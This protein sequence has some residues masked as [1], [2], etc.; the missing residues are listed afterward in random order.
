SGS[1]YVSPFLGRLDDISEDGVLLVSKIAELF[2]THNLDTQIIAASVRHPDHV[3]RVAMAGA[4]IATIP[5]SVIEQLS[6][7]PLTDQGMEK[8]AADWKKTEQL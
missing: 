8:F 7:H 4:H 2:N 1:T 5:F 6:K 3:T